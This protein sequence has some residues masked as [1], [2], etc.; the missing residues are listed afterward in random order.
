MKRYETICGARMLS[1]GS[2]VLFGGC[3]LAAETQTQTQ[4]SAAT[5]QSEAR[6]NT[7][8]EEIV[9]T[10]EKR[11]ERF[12]TSPIA[13]TAVSGSTPEKS[14]AKEVGDLVQLTPSLQFGTRST[15]VFIALRGIGQCGPGHR[16]LSQ[17]L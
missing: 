15:N 4:G 3:L 5:N 8:L 6:T 7:T 13:I 11:A 2:T 9:V 12:R 17:L 10:A 16:Q 1:V 14:G